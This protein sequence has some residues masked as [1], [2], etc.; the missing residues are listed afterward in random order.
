MTYGTDGCYS[1]EE[2]KL[3]QCG[4]VCRGQTLM[5]LVDGHEI[6]EKNCLCCQPAAFEK[7]NV[8]LQCMDGSQRTVELDVISECACQG[9]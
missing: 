4:G 6:V 3:K 9:C 8:D 5:Y 1:N 2:I 7:M